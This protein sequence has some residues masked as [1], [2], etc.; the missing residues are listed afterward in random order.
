MHY[1]GIQ[2]CLPCMLYILVPPMDL[3]GV[4]FTVME[5]PHNSI[6]NRQTILQPIKNIGICS[7][8]NLEKIE[9][10]IA[11]S[12]KGWKRYCSVV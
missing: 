1:A 2:I 9:L 5:F 3:L 4:L 6:S 12:K 11:D 10:E 8:W 7:Y